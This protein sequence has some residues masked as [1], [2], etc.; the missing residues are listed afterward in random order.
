MNVPVFHVVNDHFSGS[1]QGSC[2]LLSDTLTWQAVGTN[3]YLFLLSDGTK[4]NANEISP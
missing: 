4:V 1:G 2:A 3:R